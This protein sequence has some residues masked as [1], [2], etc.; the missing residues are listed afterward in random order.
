MECH[1]LR[2]WLCLNSHC[3]AGAASGDTA[4]CLL[5]TWRPGPIW[6]PGACVPPVVAV[7][8]V[9]V[10][11]RLWPEKVRARASGAGQPLP[12]LPGCPDVCRCC[13]SQPPMW[14]L[15]AGLPASSGVE[16]SFV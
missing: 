1:F 13:I 16:A 2:W 5:H 8:G 4:A 7:P 3:S 9:Q 15:M 14:A 11:V 10:L 6:A 12:E